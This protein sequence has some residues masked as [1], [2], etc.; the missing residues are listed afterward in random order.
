MKMDSPV[1]V[2]MEMKMD[3]CID[4]IQCYG[5]YLSFSQSLPESFDPVS[6]RSLSTQFLSSSH[7]AQ[8][9]SPDCQPSHSAHSLSPDCQAS[10]SAQSE[11]SPSAQFLSS[12]H[13]AQSLPVS[14]SLV[15]QPSVSIQSHFQVTLPR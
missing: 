12:S 6:Q 11:P 15:S 14:Y 3:Y 5:S 9:L 4:T 1:G 13:S 2:D 7:S 10:H 8:S